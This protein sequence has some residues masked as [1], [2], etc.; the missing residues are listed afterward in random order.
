M[1]LEEKT[2]TRINIARTEQA[3]EKNPTVIGAAC[4]YCL[5][6]LTDGTK[7]KELENQ[8]Q[9]LDI[10]EILERSVVGI[11]EVEIEETAV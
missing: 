1:W 6:M 4:P 7:A 9:T 10:S 8:I 11:R 3:L 5:T 2:G